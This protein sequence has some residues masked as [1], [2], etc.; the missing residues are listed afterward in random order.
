VDVI[1]ESTTG[2][3]RKSHMVT[4]VPLPEPRIAEVPSISPVPR[5]L[6]ARKETAGHYLYLRLLLT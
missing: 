6:P 3:A 1:F 4:R 2:A 5:T